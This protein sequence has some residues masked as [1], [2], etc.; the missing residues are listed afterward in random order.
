MAWLWLFAAGLFEIAGAL[1][2][3]LV[4]QHLNV[5]SV[6]GTAIAMIGSLVLL[7]LALRELPLGLSYAIW[8]GMGMAG[9]SLL[10]MTLLGEAVSL[11]RVLFLGCIAAGIVGLRLTSAG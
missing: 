2:M 6:A 1:G 9:T 8:T 5:W 3:K 4:Q 10:G 7:S 11:S